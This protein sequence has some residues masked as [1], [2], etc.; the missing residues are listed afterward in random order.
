MSHVTAVFQ[1]VTCHT[2]VFQ[3]VTCHGCV[4]GSRSRVTWLCFRTSRDTAVF[5]GV[6]CFRTSRVTAVFQGVTYPACHGMWRNWAPPLE[7]SRLATLAF[8]GS[9]AGAVF[10]MPIS[11]L[12]T[13]NISWPAPFYFYGQLPRKVVLSI[14]CYHYPRYLCSSI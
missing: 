9:Y 14:W 10:G 6:L 13:D 8:C 3:G 5:Q 2:A 1:G 7:R 11:A 4:S 12:L